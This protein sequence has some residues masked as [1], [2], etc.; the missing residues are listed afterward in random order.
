MEES[1]SRKQNCEPQPVAQPAKDGRKKIVLGKSRDKT[2]LDESFSDAEIDAAI[3]SVTERSKFTGEKRTNLIT[4]LRRTLIGEITFTEAVSNYGICVTT[5]SPYIMKARE[6]LRKIATQGNE[7]C[8]NLYHN[9]LLCCDD[10]KHKRYQVFEVPEKWKGNHT[11]LKNAIM[12]S[13]R[14]YGGGVGGESSSFMM[15]MALMD[16]LSGDCSLYRAAIKHQVPLSTLQRNFESVQEKMDSLIENNK[17]FLL[18]E[19]STASISSCVQ[20]HS[21]KHVPSEEHVQASSSAGSCESDLSRT[22]RRPCERITHLVGSR[23]RKPKVVRRIV[24]EQPFDENSSGEEFSGCANGTNGFATHS[25]SHSMREHDLEKRVNAYFSS[26]VGFKNSFFGITDE[27]QLSKIKKVVESVCQKS[28]MSDD[29][30]KDLKEAVEMVIRSRVTVTA[31]AARTSISTGTIRPY[32][33]EALQLLEQLSVSPSPEELLQKHSSLFDGTSCEN[34][35]V[36]EA[37]DIA[38]V[39]KI[40]NEL[41][42]VSALDEDGRRKI[43]ETVLRVFEEGVSASEACKMHR[44]AQTTICKYVRKCRARL[45]LAKCCERNPT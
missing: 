22:N 7:A 15:S 20:T 9:S 35:A 39:K 27:E 6:E 34:S 16:V 42:E 33:H 24:A 2:L 21:Q 11:A 40:L 1:A 4:A 32:V 43:F 28:R 45:A 19:C 3:Y 37:F 36:N 13:A 10:R 41:L 31:A 18:T 38:D 5:F 44:M 12:T 25:T 29:M 23:K 17:S 14:E 8:G 26:R 30:K